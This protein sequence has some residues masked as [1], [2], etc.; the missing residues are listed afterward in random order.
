[1]IQ[2]QASID[3]LATNSVKYSVFAVKKSNIF[4]SL[5]DMNRSSKYVSTF[6]GGE[7]G[8]QMRSPNN[9]YGFTCINFFR[10]RGVW[11][12]HIFF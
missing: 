4:S 10:W 11:D 9:S 3:I 2:L 1:M 8:A 12:K 7:N 5:A 6:S